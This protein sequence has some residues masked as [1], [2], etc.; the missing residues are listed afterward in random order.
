[1][2][3]RTSL[4]NLFREGILFLLPFGL[5]IGVIYW[6]WSQLRRFIPNL[7]VILPREFTSHENY[8]QILDLLYLF[9]ILAAITFFGVIAST[10]LGRFISF[11]IEKILLR[12]TFVRLIYSTVKKLSETIFKKED[13]VNVTDT[14]SESVLIPYPN[15]ESRSIAFITNN[16]A[17]NFLGDKE[18]DNWVTLYMPSAPV[19]TAGFLL[20]CR[21]KDIE[22]CGLSSGESMAFTIS[23]GA[24]KNVEDKTLVNK[25]K[26]PNRL[27]IWFTNGFLFLMPITA[28]V[29]ALSW[30]FNIIYRFVRNISRLVPEISISTLPH[31]YYDIVLNLIIIAILA[32]IILFIGFLGQSALGIWFKNLNN[33]IF[34]SIPMVNKIYSV[35]VQITKVFSSDPTKNNTFDQAV[36]INF[37]N[38][39]MY[40][41]GFVTGRDLNQVKEKDGGKYY[42]VFVPTTPFPTTGWFIMA[43]QEKL[44]PLDMPIEKAFGLVIS[45]GVSADDDDA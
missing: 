4:S 1:M 11:L 41:I 22:P 3:K 5:T 45:A 10:F 23:L 26:K 9:I 24:L 36:L 7:S 18:G 33:R 37:P 6:A 39:Y 35:I 17:R 43:E 16:H 15:R 38:E 27:R 40:A 29:Y 20:L 42:S 12:P 25:D 13:D 44:V 19:V 14:V 21:K 30:A 32:L 28:T 2:K 34:S 31:P 8:I